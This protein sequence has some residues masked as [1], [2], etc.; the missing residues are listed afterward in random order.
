MKPGVDPLFVLKATIYFDSTWTGTMA[1]TR[2]Q[3]CRE[4]GGNRVQRYVRYKTAK[5]LFCAGLGAEARGGLERN[6]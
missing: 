2:A 6:C 3:T 1:P 4:A 5:R